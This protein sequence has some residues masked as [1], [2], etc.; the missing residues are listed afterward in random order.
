MSVNLL[1]GGRRLPGSALSCV[2]ADA[3]EA[4]AVTSAAYIVARC[5]DPRDLVGIVAATAKVHGPIDI[6]D[7]FDHGAP[8]RVR[9]GSALLFASDAEPASELL[10]RDIASSLAPFLTETAQVRL[11]GCD[12]AVLGEPGSKDGLASRLLLLKLARA[13]GGHRVVFGT[14]TGLGRLH[15]GPRG[16]GRDREEVMLFSSLA[17][18]D[19]APPDEGIRGA[20]LQKLRPPQ[21]NPYG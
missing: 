2:D 5:D 19:I 21:Y 14:I 8:G 13:L 9:M 6:L 12:T 16:F 18:V 3:V 4:M 17:A 11:L 15:F 1:V 20:E 7:L 10:G